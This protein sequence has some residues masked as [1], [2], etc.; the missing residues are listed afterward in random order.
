MQ[1]TPSQPGIIPRAVDA[2]FARRDALLAAQAD[3][4]VEEQYSI[5]LTI[6]YMEIYKDEVYDLLVARDNAPKLPVRENDAG[7]VFVANLSSV[8]VE[9]PEEFDQIYSCV[10]FN[11]LLAPVSYHW[12]C[13]RAMKS[14]SVASTN[15]NRA[16]SR[17]HAILTVIVSLTD[18]SGNKSAFLN[19]RQRLAGYPR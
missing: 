15:L 4:P 16:S 17:S 7:Q 8:P 13:R 18:P 5:E 6:S 10:L 1:G 14:R 11:S 19:Y 3:D 2:L 9:T 12:L